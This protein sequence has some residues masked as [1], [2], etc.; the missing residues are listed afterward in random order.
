[1][2]VAKEFSVRQLTSLAVARAE[3]GR[4]QGLLWGGRCFPHAQG[5]PGRW[6]HME[7]FKQE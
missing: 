7:Q 4:S 2:T 1:M 6:L 3:L 5:C